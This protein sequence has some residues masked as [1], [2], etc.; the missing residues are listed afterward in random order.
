MK[1]LLFAIC[2]LAA[3]LPAAA[4]DL[5]ERYGENP[6]ERRENA[7]AYQ[8]FRQR[9]DMKYIDG[10]TIG[11]LQ[12]LLEKAPRVSE[13]I[14]IY[15]VNIYRDKVKNAADNAERAIML[16]SI[17]MLYDKR[18]ENFGDD[19]AGAGR[20]RILKN[21]A[22]T[23]KE[24][25]P[26]DREKIVALFREAVDVGD[27]KLEGETITAYYSELATEYADNKV[28]MDD[29][30]GEFDR[31]M[32]LASALE[33]GNAIKGLQ[34]ILISSG[35]ATSETI[36]KTFR[37]LIAE[38]PNNG[39]VLARAIGLLE[40]IGDRGAFYFEVA[41]LYHK[42][43]PSYQTAS[44]LAN[45]YLQKGDNQ[46]ALKYLNDAMAHTQDTEG[47]LELSLMISTTML[48]MGN[49]REAY[50]YANKAIEISPNDGRAYY[51]IA[52]AYASGANSCGDDF[53]KRTVYW[54]VV[55]ALK[56]ARTHLANMPTPPIAPRVIDQQIASYTQ[57]FP[58]VQELF[59]RSLDEGA[60]YKVE[61]G[62]INKN[63]TVR[64]KP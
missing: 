15:G 1:K 12:R 39:D 36:E 58:D 9:Y 47:K 48:K 22:A 46:T 62:W 4:Q 31:M 33:D 21:K 20:A 45:Y 38:D 10:E 49:S 56:L 59:F 50:N 17:M 57:S 41:E 6:E 42:A 54:I 18:A 34:A 13:N 16:D 37:P 24:F 19:P 2:L 44:I 64:R 43:A 27:E 63:T 5:D 40:R 29:I 55:D 7:I 60:S 32:A 30:L 11:F 25:N 8:F 35:A 28:G 51:M 61:C 23:Y 53:Q 14:Y 26:G 3:A 52:Q